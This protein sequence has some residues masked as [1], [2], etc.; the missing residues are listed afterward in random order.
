MNYQRAT[1]ARLLLT[2][3]VVLLGLLGTITAPTAVRAE[4]TTNNPCVGVDI[5]V[6]IDQSTSMQLNDPND[7]RIESARDIIYLLGE[8]RIY[9]CQDAIHRVAV[10]SFGDQGNDGDATEVDLDF[11]PIEPLT[12]TDKLNLWDTE[13]DHLDARIQPKQ[14]GATDFAAAFRV[15][16][17]QFD[18]LS[19]IGT[20]PRKKVIIL[21]TDGGPCITRLGCRVVNSTFSALPYLTDLQQQIES[22]F[23]FQTGLGYYLWVVTMQDRGADYLND[24]V[25]NRTLREYWNALAI[26]HGGELI[27]LTKNREDM[28]GTYYNLLK[29]FTGTGKVESIGCTPKYIDPYTASVQFTIYKSWP[30]LSVSIEHTSNDGQVLTLKDGQASGGTVDIEEYT[31]HRVVEHYVIRSPAIGRWQ[32]K[33]DN[34]ADL[35]VYRE[36][37]S[38]QFNLIQPVNPVLLYDQAPFYDPHNPIHLTYQVKD[39][40]AQVANQ[41]MYP[42]NMIATITSP[43]NQVVTRTMVFSGTTL[44][45]TEPLIVGEVG[46]YRIHLV[47]EAPSAD[48]AQSAPISVFTREDTYRVFVEVQPFEVKILQPEANGISPMQSATGDAQAPLQV[49]I[50]LSSR[51]GHTLDP[52]RVFTG[53]PTEAIVV[54]VTNAQQAKTPVS[55]SPSPDDPALLVGSLDLPE[56]SYTIQADVRGTYRQDRFQLVQT[57]VTQSFQRVQAQFFNFEVVEPKPGT[58]LP[59]NSVADGQEQTLPLA[60]RIRLV[61]IA[62]KPIDASKPFPDLTTP[63]FT[64]TLHGPAGESLNVNLQ[65]DPANPGLFQADV[66]D[67]NAPGPHRIDVALARRP[68]DVRYQPLK[69]N[70]QQTAFSRMRVEPIDFTIIAPSTDSQAVHV[71]GFKAALDQ[72]APLQIA[73]EV[74]ERDGQKSRDPQTV[75]PS[76]PAQSVVAT[77]VAP[78]GI[79][80]TIGLQMI[81]MPDRTVLQGTM[82]DLPA[83]EGNYQLFVQMPN[84]KPGFAPLH[85]TK[86]VSFIR[87][88]TNWATSPLVWRGIGGVIVLLLLILVGFIVWIIRNAPRGDIEVTGRSGGKAYATLHWNNLFIPLRNNDLR[89]LGIGQIKARANREDPND[90]AINIWVSNTIGEELII[91]QQLASGQSTTVTVVENDKLVSGTLLYN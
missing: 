71:E 56:G 19:P 38:P 49:K 80:R 1:S 47:G 23:P 6:M 67:L 59:L 13:R 75:L 52:S 42:L 79:T 21:L 36:L 62:G 50:Q 5:A 32:V 37:I 89:D 60:V 41:P 61:D 44:R 78:G 31:S 66:A 58:T 7:F 65:P 82:T 83:L 73:I 3:T 24:H 76:D 86:E 26:S 12:T 8:N 28:L 14:L 2:F 34:C 77:V 70:P 54:S 51:D 33:S 69:A 63:I 4:P 29:S 46:A 64:A 68:T 15:A 22:D 40:I 35:L 20:L 81:K 87:R 10:I 85:P 84:L 16:K 45:S 17:H 57:P 18:R 55:L 27:P 88:D 53:N 11:V 25:G 39:Q 74:T 91:G 72:V 48:P 43:S 90:K 9:L 30:E